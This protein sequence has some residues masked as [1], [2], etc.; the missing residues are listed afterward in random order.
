MTSLICVVLV[1]VG[2]FGGIYLG[3]STLIF[4]GLAAL[5]VEMI[6][7]VIRFLYRD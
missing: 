5:I 2:L 7:R 1:L 4:I 6:V 3:N